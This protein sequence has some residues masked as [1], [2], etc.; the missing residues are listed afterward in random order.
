MVTPLEH[1]DHPTGCDCA[2]CIEVWDE[3]EDHTNIDNFKDW[4]DEVDAQI[5]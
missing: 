4:L 2:T 5:N 1:F 3:A